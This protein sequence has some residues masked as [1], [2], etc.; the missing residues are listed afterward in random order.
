[1]VAP[2]PLLA[3]MLLVQKA[4]SA[5]IETLAKADLQ[6]DVLAVFTFESKKKDLNGRTLRQY[7]SAA[8]TSFQQMLP[9]NLAAAAAI[10]DKL[11]TA[12]L[13]VD[14]SGKTLVKLTLEADSSDS[15]KVLHDLLEQGL[16]FG[17]G[18]MVTGGKDMLG[19]LGPAGKTAGKTVDEIIDGL[20]LSQD[21]AEVRLK[22][23]TPKALPQ[24]VEQLAPIMNEALKPPPPRK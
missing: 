9:P 4:K 15:A 3:K 20:T 18:F 24:L 14:L 16:V 1:V 12:M 21:G 6:N 10:P 7:A 2:E 23:P 19:L 22:V 11:K 17:K 8:L 13:T 5:L